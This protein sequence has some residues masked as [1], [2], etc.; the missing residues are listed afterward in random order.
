[1]REL[2]SNE[3]AAVNGGHDG[4]HEHSY[5]SEFWNSF[6]HSSG[7]A[8]GI[9]WSPFMPFIMGTAAVLGAFGSA[10]GYLFSGVAN[11][12]S[13]IAQSTYSAVT[14]KTTPAV[15]SFSPVESV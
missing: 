15:T 4:A 12:A 1:M 5:Q 13:Y 2:T 7:F 10:V 9:F 6:L 11:G 8:A 14:T 3:L